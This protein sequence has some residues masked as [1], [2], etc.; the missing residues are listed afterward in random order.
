MI[1]LKPRPHPLTNYQPT[2]STGQ[3][4]DMRQHRLRHN[5]CKSPGF[6]DYIPYESLAIWSVMMSMQTWY[7]ASKMESKLFLVCCSLPPCDV[8]SRKTYDDPRDSS[9]PVTSFFSFVHLKVYRIMVIPNSFFRIILPLA[10]CSWPHSSLYCNTEHIV[11][12]VIVTTE[13]GKQKGLK[14][15][16]CN[17]STFLNV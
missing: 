8:K 9:S 14:M 10:Y 13:Y 4:Y 12:C 5:L 3:R 15:I 2:L 1:R 16:I 17:E 6:I 7:R 11:D